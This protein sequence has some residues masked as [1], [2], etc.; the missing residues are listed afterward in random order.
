M[1]NKIF[2]LFIAILTVAIV[3]VSLTTISLQKG[4]D[5]QENKIERLQDK[6]TLH[7]KQVQGLVKKTEE[8]RRSV[9]IFWMFVNKKEWRIAE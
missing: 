1:L 3:E 6:Q 9:N 8:L 7:D 4:L 5:I 2:L